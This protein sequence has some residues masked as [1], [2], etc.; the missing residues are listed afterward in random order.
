M[1]SAQRSAQRYRV[2]RVILAGE[3]ES[4]DEADWPATDDD[5]VFHRPVFIA[6]DACY[7]L[8]TKKSR[9]TVKLFGD[10][11]AL[12]GG[13]WSRT[14]FAGGRDER[15]KTERMMPRMSA[16]AR[17]RNSPRRINRKAVAVDF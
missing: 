9:V 14:D 5:H 6:G 2:G 17:S 15:Q 1:C 7:P 4:S 3:A 8:A 10:Q 16:Q 12:D 11:L 13:T